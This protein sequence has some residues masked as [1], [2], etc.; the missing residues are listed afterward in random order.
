ML[1]ALLLR[2]RP[3]RPLI[4]PTPLA[5]LGGLLLG[6]VVAGAVLALVVVPLLS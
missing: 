6:I 1:G 4:E 2:N 5:Y 3:V